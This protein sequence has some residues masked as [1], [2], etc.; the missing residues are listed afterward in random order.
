MIFIFRG[1]S[2]RSPAPGARL[3]GQLLTMPGRPSVKVARSLWPGKWKGWGADHF[4]WIR[5]A[6]IFNHV[7]CFAAISRPEPFGRLS[8]ALLQPRGSQRPPS[9]ILRC[10]RR[11]RPH[12]QTHGKI[13]G[14]LADLVFFELPPKAWQKMECPIGRI[15]AQARSKGGKHKK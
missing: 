14:K 15:L 2:R 4:R 3:L 7:F 8:F 12:R 13:V 10:Q 1:W 6:S 9:K 5:F 11:S